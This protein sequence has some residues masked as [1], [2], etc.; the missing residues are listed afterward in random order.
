MPYKG[1]DTSVINILIIPLITVSVET[2]YA[3]DNADL[4]IGSNGFH[5]AQL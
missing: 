5:K 1:V 4:K 3:D 2:A